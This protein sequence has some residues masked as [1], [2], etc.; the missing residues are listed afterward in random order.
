MK[1]T[2]KSQ[3]MYLCIVRPASHSINWTINQGIIPYIEP[4]H[5]RMAVFIKHP[6]SQ[7]IK[8]KINQKSFSEKDFR[9]KFG[10]LF[11]CSLTDTGKSRINIMENLKLSHTVPSLRLNIKPNDQFLFPDTLHLFPFYQ[12]LR[13]KHVPQRLALTASLMP[14]YSLL[15]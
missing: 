5:F 12:H 3:S 4:F 14:P 13:V 10:K 11:N 15:L 6:A 2:L 7:S 8:L 9:I 1:Q